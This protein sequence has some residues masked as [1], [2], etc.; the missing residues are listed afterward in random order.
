[1]FHVKYLGS[2]A[3]LSRSSQGITTEMLTQAVQRALNSS[4]N[5]GQGNQETSSTPAPQVNYA[6][7]TVVGICHFFIIL[8]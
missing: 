8:I 3:R 7:V 4:A 1:M 6:P 2:S 5:T